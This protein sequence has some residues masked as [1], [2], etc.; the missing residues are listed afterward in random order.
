MVRAI[1]DN[2]AGEKYINKSNGK[3]TKERREQIKHKLRFQFI[4]ITAVFIPY[5]VILFATF[6]F[7]IFD[8]FVTL[9]RVG[10]RTEVDTSSG[11]I[12][13]DPMGWIYLAAFLVL[14]TP[15]MVYQMWFYLKSSNRW[16]GTG[17][18]SGKFLFA[19]TV[20]GCLLIIIGCLIPFYPISDPRSTQAM[21]D[22]HN[23]LA[24]S[25]SLLT[26][27]AVTI[28]LMQVAREK[29]T[30][31]IMILYALFVAL[32]YY[33]YTVL[34]NAIAF[35]VGLTFAV[36]LLMYFINRAALY[37]SARNSPQ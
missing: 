36:F 4:Y 3:I 19:L 6:G 35:E 11:K 37:Q 34:V 9:S 14:S 26:V 23:F 8:K 17:R 20:L 1:Y 30:Q 7:D 28:A 31:A 15:F 16:K 22:W 25:G 21:H 2:E 33:V 32:V 24:V 13:E 12:I 29:N 5:I 10:W 18:S 27:A